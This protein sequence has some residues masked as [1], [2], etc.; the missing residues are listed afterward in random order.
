MVTVRP[1]QPRSGEIEVISGGAGC[2]GAGLWKQP[3][4]KPSRKKDTAKNTRKRSEKIFSTTP[5]LKLN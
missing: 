3:D 2:G 4:T 1:A 5:P